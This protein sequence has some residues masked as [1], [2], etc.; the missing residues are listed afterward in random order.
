MY[1]KFND[2]H[3]ELNWVNIRIEIRIQDI[4]FVF[5]FEVELKYGKR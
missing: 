1:V 5:V 4:Y 3:F 2:T